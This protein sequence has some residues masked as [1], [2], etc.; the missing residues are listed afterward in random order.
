MH[1]RVRSFVFVVTAVVALGVAAAPA[2]AIRA[3]DPLPTTGSGSAAMPTPAPG[4]RPSSAD[5]QL[6][7]RVTDNA[8]LPVGPTPTDNRVEGIA[9]LPVPT[10]TPTPTPAPGAVTAEACTELL[11]AN[12]G[13]ADQVF[14]TV[15]AEQAKQLVVART[16][17]HQR[18]AASIARN[19]KHVILAYVAMWLLAVGFVVFLWRRQAGLKAQIDTL[20]ADLERAT[21]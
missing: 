13:V 15:N 5:D 21:K 6:G 1:A 9:A 17:M 4:P 7:R 18:A 2:F 19:E 11:L 10:P 16:E 3:P 14:E 12:R 8:V 20:R